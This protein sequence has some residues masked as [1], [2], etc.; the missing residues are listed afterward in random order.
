MSQSI[1]IDARKLLKDRKK[2]KRSSGKLN[3]SLTFKV[4]PTKLTISAEDYANY[5]DKGT[6][7]FKGNSF[8]TDAVE[9]NIKTYGDNLTEE[10]GEQ[11]IEELLKIE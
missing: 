7:N 2:N 6:R 5:V 11:V 1:I 8:L 3:R 10:L 4:E 9:S